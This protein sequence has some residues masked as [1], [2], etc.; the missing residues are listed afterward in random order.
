[1]DRECLQVVTGYTACWQV[2]T[3]WEGGREGGE[4]GR[5]GWEGVCTDR[6]DRESRYVQHVCADVGMVVS[7]GRRGERNTDRSGASSPSNVLPDKWV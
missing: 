5:E 4:G 3:C 6:V 7:G 2:C 1:M